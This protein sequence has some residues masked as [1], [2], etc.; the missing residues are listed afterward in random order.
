MV[1]MAGAGTRGKKRA[2]E[3][4]RNVSSREKENTAPTRKQKQ[5]EEMRALQK[6][7]DDVHE[8]ILSEE[9]ISEIVAR[10]IARALQEF[11]KSNVTLGKMQQQKN[12][13]FN[14][15]KDVMDDKTAKVLIRGCVNVFL[16]PSNAT[17]P[18][19]C[20]SQLCR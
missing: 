12:G 15:M 7:I 20:Y 2:K 18:N 5:T 4:E 9:D 13:M 17:W 19:V 8:S 14:S 3:Q 1:T 11:T 16:V 10:E 6:E